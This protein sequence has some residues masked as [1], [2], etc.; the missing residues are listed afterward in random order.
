[1][2]MAMNRKEHFALSLFCILL[3][4]SAYTAP[5]EITLP[6]ETATLRESTL[7]GYTLA[8]QKCSIC[9]SVDYIKFQPPGM[10]LE[11]WTDEMTKMQ[12]SYGAPIDAQEIGSIAAYL[13]VSYG[14]AE[15]TDAAVIAASAPKSATAAATIDVDELLNANTCMGCHSIDTKIVGPAFH[16]VATKYADQ[17]NAESKLSISIKSGGAGKWGQIPMPPMSGLSDAQA[18]ALAAYIL[19]Q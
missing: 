6:A 17:A 1:M 2:E 19:K 9:H 7:P 8:L 5:V 10:T 4:P 16:D 15:A 11:Q 18:K 3:A 14:S 13:A 12:H